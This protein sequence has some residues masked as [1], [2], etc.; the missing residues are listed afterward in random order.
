MWMEILREPWKPIVLALRSPV[1]FSRSAARQFASLEQAQY[2]P[3]QLHP[4]LE[5]QA[6]DRLLPEKVL[7][8]ARPEPLRGLAMLEPATSVVQQGSVLVRAG[9]GQRPPDHLVE[10]APVSKPIATQWLSPSL[11]RKP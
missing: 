8:Q 3:V 4:V 5:R 6:T 11:R 2:R 10:S 9:F 7:R 1:S